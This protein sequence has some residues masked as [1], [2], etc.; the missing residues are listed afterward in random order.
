MNK[1]LQDITDCVPHS[2][3]KVKLNRGQMLYEQGDVIAR[4]YFPFSAVIS[5][6][7]VTGQGEMVEV[8]TVGNE[9]VLGVGRLIGEEKAMARA[10][11]LAP[12]SAWRA[13]AEG[14][15]RE[16]MQR[17][18]FLSRVRKYAQAFLILIARSS[19]CN[20]L[21][22]VEERCARWF[23][24]TRDRTATDDLIITQEALA[25]LLGVRRQTAAIVLASLEQKGFIEL[26]RKRIRIRNHL[27]LESAA[28]ECYGIVRQELEQ[29]HAGSGVGHP[30]TLRFRGNEHMTK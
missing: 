4:V 2:W 11:V 24:M 14:F 17:P 5:L 6:L 26:R 30:S 19:G 8:A 23:L 16:L 7:V 18:A 3:E 28:C 12:G 21:H 13:S 25:D 29:V 10:V 22:S 20:R 27:G 9:G 15:E 1:L